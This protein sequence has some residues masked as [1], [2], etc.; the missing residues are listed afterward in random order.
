[1]MLHHEP[2]ISIF[3]RSSP[4]VFNLCSLVIWYDPMTS[5][6]SQIFLSNVFGFWHLQIRDCLIGSKVGYN[7]HIDKMNEDITNTSRNTFN[8]CQLHEV[9]WNVIET[10]AYTNVRCKHS[11]MVEPWLRNGIHEA[12]EQPKKEKSSAISNK[13]PEINFG[14]H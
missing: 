4:P 3:R 1:M 9:I 8:Q 10:K 7:L 14:M 12:I 11:E 2:P 6:Y 13:I 5:L